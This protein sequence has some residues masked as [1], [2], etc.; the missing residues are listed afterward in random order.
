MRAGMSA[1][2]LRALVSLGLLLAILAAAAGNA[3]EAFEYRL[4]PTDR[5][6]ITVFGHEDLSGEFEVDGTG[7]VS[8]PLIR[9]VP[10][11]G[12]TTQELAATIARKLQPDYLKE[13]RVSVDVINY[14]PFYII[15][16]VRNP[17]SY[18]FVNNMT[19][20][21]AVAVAGGYTYRASKKK[22]TV[23][24]ADDATKEKQRVSEDTRIYPGDVVE[25][26]ERYF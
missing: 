11:S 1:M 2:R 10:A 16:E 3:E 15:G 20:V 26:P 5:V 12:L 4:G 25:V 21:N 14:R 7:N 17:G 18:P 19:V 6:R 9:I 8:L 23:I 13:P 24:R 22:I